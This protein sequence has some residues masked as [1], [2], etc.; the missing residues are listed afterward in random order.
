VDKDSLILMKGKIIALFAEDFKNL[1][2]MDDVL[3]ERDNRLDSLKSDIE[4]DEKSET[5]IFSIYGKSRVSKL[6]R[7]VNSLQKSPIQFIIASDFIHLAY[8]KY[9]PINLEKAKATF[10]TQFSISIL[11][12]ELLASHC[13]LEQ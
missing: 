10:G 7:A 11:K 2:A 8:R 1:P 3:N 6:C 4:D 5:S 13:L 9:D 12:L